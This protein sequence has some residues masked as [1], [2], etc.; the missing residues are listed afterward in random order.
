[1]GQNI[2][3]TTYSSS[4]K[5]N[6]IDIEESEIN[7]IVNDLNDG[8]EYNNNRIKDLEGCLERVEVAWAKTSASRNY[9]SAMRN[10]YCKDLEKLNESIESY[11]N[12]LSNVYKE[13]KDVDEK[14]ASELS[15]IEVVL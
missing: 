13:Y 4:G 6:I 15:S 9:V 10:K 12:F 5:G 2:S 14:C 1:M 8:I 7:K 3:W 11:K